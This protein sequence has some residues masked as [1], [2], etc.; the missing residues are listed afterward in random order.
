MRV[1]I[2]VDTIPAGIEGRDSLYQKCFERGIRV[3][4]MTMYRRQEAGPHILLGKY[5]R[6][7]LS[8]AGHLDQRR[9]SS[10]PHAVTFS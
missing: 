2:L 9:S 6:I 8:L 1:P 3:R 10:V 4:V 7:I 5:L